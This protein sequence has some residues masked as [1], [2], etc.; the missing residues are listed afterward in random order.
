MKKWYVVHTQTGVE[1][2]VKANLEK[3]ISSSQDKDSFGQV[4]IPTEQISEIRSG[5]KKSNPEKIFSGIFIGRD[6]FE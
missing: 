6:G 3:R 5:K 1:E 4:M 2:K